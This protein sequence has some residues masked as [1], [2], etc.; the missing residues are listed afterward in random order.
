MTKKRQLE[1]TLATY[2]MS[3]GRFSDMCNAKNRGEAF[4][5]EEFASDTARHC[6]TMLFCYVK[7]VTQDDL[8]LCGNVGLKISED[9]VKRSGIT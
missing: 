9:Y 2:S 1:V 3:S 4:K 8:N 7:N 6:Q 5:W